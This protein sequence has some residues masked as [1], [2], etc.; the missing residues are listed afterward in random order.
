MR[1]LTCALGVLAVLSL[2]ACKEE[3]SVNPAPP[4]PPV[5]PRLSLSRVLGSY[6][7]SMLTA[8]GVEAVVLN[9]QEVVPSGEGLTFRYR[10]NVRA[11]REDGF[12]TMIIEGSKTRVCF[13][14]QVCGWLLTEGDRVLIAAETQPGELLPVWSVEKQ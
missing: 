2:S 3:A 7:G 6:S 4:L 9:I 10:M 13:S 1:L 14:A 12:G 5:S 11:L 8:S